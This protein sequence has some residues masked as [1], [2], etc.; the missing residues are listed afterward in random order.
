MVQGVKF[1]SAKGHRY[2]KTKTLIKGLKFKK[3]AGERGLVKQTQLRAKNL[4]YRPLQ[5]DKQKSHL[6]L[7]VKLKKF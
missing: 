4:V 1:K 5:Q 2:S 3:G 7:K 6:P